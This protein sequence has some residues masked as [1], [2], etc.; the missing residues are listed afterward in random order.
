MKLLG[1]DVEDAGYDPPKPEKG[2]GGAVPIGKEKNGKQYATLYLNSREVSAI[3][4]KDVKDKCVMVCV[5]EVVSR[6][7]R[8][9]TRE[10]KKAEMETNVELRI[11]KAGFKP[12]T[13]KKDP[14][15]M[16]DEELKENED[17]GDE[18]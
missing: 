16:S 14:E 17:Y 18:E 12:Y 2:E 4:S 5:V 10:G 1:V 9:E 7:E 3:K 8:E 15:E 11:L 6:T 13:G